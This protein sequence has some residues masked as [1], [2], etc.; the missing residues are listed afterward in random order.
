MD[1]KQM[2]ASVVNEETKMVIWHAARLADEQRL[3]QDFPYDKGHQVYEEP[4]K[5][6]GS[7]P[8][9]HPSSVGLAE[10][11]VHLI[12]KC[13]KAHMVGMTLVQYLR[14]YCNGIALTGVTFHL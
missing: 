2:T 4:Q 12:L 10:W 7:C 13:Y 1:V 11:Y 5:E 9:M 14:Q 3:F 8:I 6:G